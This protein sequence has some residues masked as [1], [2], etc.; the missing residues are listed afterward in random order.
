[1]DLFYAKTP[2]EYQ[3]VFYRQIGLKV[4]ETGELERNWENP[5]NGSIRSYGSIGQIQFGTGSY[6]IPS[7]FLVEYQYST[8]Y[9]HFGIIYEG[10][11]YSLVEDRL[12]A[13]SIPSAF[14]AIEKAAGGVNCWKKG[15]RFKGVEVSV[16]MTYLKT[17]LLPFLQVSGDEL[18]FLEEN[19]RYIR[20][21]KEMRQLIW[22][23]EH[24]MHTGKMTK[25]LQISIC[26]EF[27]AHLLHPKNREIFSCQEQAFAKYVQVG[28]RKIKM[29][30][31]DFQK[32]VTAH[33]RIEKDAASFYTIYELS[34][35]LGISEQKLKVGFKELYQQ[36]LWDYANSVRMNAAIILLHDTELSIKE[37]SG[38][39]GYQSQVAFTN[40]FKKWSGITP[41]H[42]RAQVQSMEHLR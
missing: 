41:G 4:E 17:V 37:I 22:H 1:M 7:D 19:V 5:Q 20:L 32:V 40:M 33:E 18:C 24:L 2:S 6:R 16:E 8:E 25:P 28:K 21:P 29:T 13:Q 10:I 39:V 34:R 31:E 9:L 23:I 15:Q 38:K 11:T 42:F 27:I 12:E 35:E 14:L 36:T 30:K 3:D 26:L